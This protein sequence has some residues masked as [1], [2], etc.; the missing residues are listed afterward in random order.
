MSSVL[1]RSGVCKGVCDSDIQITKPGD[2]G[3]KYSGMEEVWTLLLPTAGRLSPVVLGC[4]WKQQLIHCPQ[5][6]AQSTLHH[7]AI[8]HI[9]FLQSE[10][11]DT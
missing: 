4:V 6:T 11:E 10:C 3:T 1:G 5:W 8:D 7:K 9:I 2:H